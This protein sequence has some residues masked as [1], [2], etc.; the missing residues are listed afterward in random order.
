MITFSK[1]GLKGR[2]G[3]QL[4]QIAS[5]LS[6]SLNNGRFFGIY[7]WEYEKYF[8][9]TFIKIPEMRKAGIEIK[10]S[11][12]HY[13]KI[14]LPKEGSYDLN[15][16]F[17]SYKYFENCEDIIKKQFEFKDDLKSKC[18]LLLPN[19]D[20]ENIA[21]HVRRTDYVNNPSHY[22]LS[23][24]YYLNA[25]EAFGD[26][27]SYNIIFFSD[28]IEYCKWHF[29]CL[30][31]AYF[32]HGTEIEDLCTMSLC[33]HFIIANSSF[34]W[35]GGWLCKSPDKIIVRPKEHFAGNQ[36]K[37][38]IKDLYPEDWIVVSDET[39]TVLL[40]T[41]FIIPV[42]FDHGDRKANLELSIKHLQQTFDT[43]INL[44]EQNGNHFQYLEGPCDYAT[45]QG[46]E[47]HRTRMINT[48]AKFVRTD[49]VVNWDADVIL[50]P[51]QIWYS[52]QLLRAGIDVVYPYDGNFK[53]IPRP[54]HGAL[55][56]N[57]SYLICKHFNGPTES[58]GGAIFMNRLKFISV[59]GE[60][61][62]FISW[63]PEDAERFTRF[64][65]MGLK[66]DRIKGWLYHLEHYRGQNSGRRN[67]YLEAN[68]KE[69]HMIRLMEPEALKE[70]IK[71]WPWI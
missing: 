63:G 32:I 66:V 37:H 42:A 38:D 65:K 56:N 25:L 68:R 13:N 46:K 31:N 16:Y 20:K 48:I 29:S 1:L 21:I 49:Y 4:W 33:D 27:Q 39:K 58:W 53:N 64:L 34:S 47:F 35:W 40:D 67:P 54:L 55:K 45:Y 14:E 62:K 71:T 23:I 12:F 52:V 10:E 15:G 6:I 36:L 7:N 59:G 11:A 2:L 17:Q 57:L 9:G 50:N 60:N 28:D 41:T 51:V 26:W 8:T 19:N 3:N 30:P 70:Y 44:I 43:N 24:R 5:S 18:Q 69:W 61:E 22:N